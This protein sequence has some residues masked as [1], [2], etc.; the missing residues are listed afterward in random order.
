[1]RAHCMINF[2]ELSSSLLMMKH[3]RSL[4]I[5][6]LMRCVSMEPNLRTIGDLLQILPLRTTGSFTLW[7]EAGATRKI[8]FSSLYERILNSSHQITCLNTKQRRLRWK[9]HDFVR[10]H[11]LHLLAFDH[12]RR[13]SGSLVLERHHQS[14]LLQLEHGLLH[15]LRR[16][17]ILWFVF[18][19]LLFLQVCEIANE[20]DC[21]QYKTGNVEGP[22][23]VSGTT[24]YYRGHAVLTGSLLFCILTSFSSLTK[25]YH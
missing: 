21:N 25:Q 2:V 1:M 15:L 6:L 3:Y 20:S 19:I 17:L 9:S 13:Y 22:V 8:A 24:I 12:E 18:R 11:Q 14:R 10:I 5:L 16:W 23:D 7:V 4:R